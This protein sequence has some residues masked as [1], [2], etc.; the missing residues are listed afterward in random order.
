MDFLA[1][2]LQSPIL[3]ANKWKGVKD[4]IQEWKFRKADNYLGILEINSKFIQERIQRK[5]MQNTKD[6][7]A[8]EMA[9]V[10]DA[11]TEQAEMLARM[12]KTL[13]IVVL[14]Y[15]QLFHARGASGLNLEEIKVEIFK[16]YLTAIDS[17]GITTSQITK[18]G[19]RRIRDEGGAIR[20]DEALGVRSDKYNLILSMNRVPLLRGHVDRSLDRNDREAYYPA[21]NEQGDLIFNYMDQ[22][23]APH[24]LFTTGKN[25]V[26]QPNKSA[27][28]HFDYA[29][30]RLAEGLH[31]H[32]N[33]DNGR[34]FEVKS[35]YR[36]LPQ[37][38]VYNY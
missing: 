32:F 20:A 11:V 8:I 6:P 16:T 13:D 23:V 15:L 24:V 28:F 21:L 30:L 1:H 17:L 29:R 2:Q 25:S 9:V 36:H 26:A 35:E 33:L 12:G 5:G 10:M 7:I 37:Y 38:A 3:P 31:R 27:I 4:A 22:V 34:F 14:D 18:D 19:E